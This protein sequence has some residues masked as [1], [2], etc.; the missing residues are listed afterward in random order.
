MKDTP[1]EINGS[2]Q[3]LHN[4]LVFGRLLRRLGLDV[5]P[6]RMIDLVQA[7]DLIE[8]G[9]KE[10]FYH[11]TRSLLV[12]RREDIPLFD[13]AFELFWRKPVE[14]W[15]DLGLSSMAKQK[16]RGP[17][18]IPPPL[19]PAEET[20]QR[21]TDNEASESEE[22]IVIET[23]KTYSNREVLWK[24]DFA[25]LSPQEIE[26]VKDMMRQL[27][28]RLGE[29]RTRRKRPGNG[30]SIDLRR[31][32]R[33]SYSYGGE[34]LIWARRESKFKL[35]PLVIIADI[36]GS[37]ERYTRLL[38]HFIYGLSHSL[39]QPVEAFVFGTRLTRITRQLRNRDID[40]ALMGV[41]L[42]V[43]DW[44]GGTRIGESLKDFNF[45]WGRR[46]LGHGA[47]VLIISD[48]WDRGDMDVLEREMAR[49]QRSCYRLIWLNPL[50]GSPT[51]E[52]L[53]RGMQTALPYTDNFLP[54]HNL[55]SLE[56]LTQ[57]LQ[58]INQNRPVRRQI[59]MDSR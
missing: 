11:T 55:A 32:L 21:E 57:H 38:L 59:N 30:H 20:P 35:R 1:L 18:F 28:L 14:E 19:Q 54:V 46:V 37:M 39:H 3:F 8:I 48:G 22:R 47:V 6:G 58:A 45:N 23:T 26:A 27:T 29:R 15:G 43:L 25:D 12:H 10:D 31:T 13:Q 52:P 4:L 42:A 44:A 16:P 34:V 33:N 56:D 50:L 36:S 49:L 41:S 9:R 5:N 51:Y 53:T 40:Q 17:Q 24:K 7:L 2:G